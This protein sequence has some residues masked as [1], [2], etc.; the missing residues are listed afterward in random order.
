VNC[1]RY[2]ERAVLVC[3]GTVLEIDAEQLNEAMAVGSY[4][5]RQTAWD[6]G[7]GEV[8][9]ASH[10][11][12]VRPAAVKLIRHDA[13]PGAARE[14]LVR[15][16]RARSA[17]DRGTASRRTRCS[18][19]TSAST[20]PEAFYY[21]M[22]YLDGLD[23]HRL[24][25][26]SGRSR[27]ARHHALASG[28][29]IARRAHARGLVHRDIKPANIFVTRLGTEFDYVKILDFG[30]VKEQSDATPRCFR[31]TV[32]CRAPLRSCLRKS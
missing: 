27:R 8:W 28:V 13:A 18:C 15:R 5:P 6:R 30:V 31:I 32:S 25:T 22:E 23:L 10:R 24:V 4:P 14:Q 16:F 21:V 2:F 12:L 29:S 19:T 9:L 11:F 17:R 7:M 3:K 1:E 26:V 20:T